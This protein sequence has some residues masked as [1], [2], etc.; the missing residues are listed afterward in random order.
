MLWTSNVD[1]ACRQFGKLIQGQAVNAQSTPWVVDVAVV[2]CPQYALEGAVRSVR[3]EWSPGDVATRSRPC[4][5][6]ASRCLAR[7]FGRD[8]TFVS[9]NIDLPGRVDNVSSA[10]FSGISRAFHWLEGIHPCL[11]LAKAIPLRLGV[12]KGRERVPNRTIGRSQSQSLVTGG[13]RVDDGMNQRSEPDAGFNEA[14][15]WLCQREQ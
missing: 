15:F 12:S 6:L 4:E 11:A 3:M 14:V 5:P 2:N 9:G 8:R 7:P 1:Y 13:I 10:V